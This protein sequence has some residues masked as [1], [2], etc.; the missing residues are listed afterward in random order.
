MKLRKIFNFIS[1]IMLLWTILSG[2]YLGLPQEI[3]D[4]IPKLTPFTMA[5]TGG[6]TGILGTTILIVD[7]FLKKN[8]V[9]VDTKYL[10]LATKFLALSDKYLNLEK[11]VDRNTETQ[12]KTNELIDKNNRLLGIDLESKLSNPLVENFIKEKIRGEGIGQKE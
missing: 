3:K 2:I 7:R 5:L 8:Q 10:D 11:K 1:F 6:S 4:M 12:N 9:E